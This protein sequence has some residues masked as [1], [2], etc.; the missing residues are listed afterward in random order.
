MKEVI[1]AWNESDL[2]C[3]VCSDDVP[4]GGRGT[5]LILVA[6]DR[7]QRSRT[8]VEELIGIV[9][10][11]GAYRQTQRDAADDASVRA[12]GAKADIRPER[13][14]GKQKRQMEGAIKPVESRSHVIL[15]AVSVIEVAHTQADAAE[16]EA[17]NGNAQT[18]ENLGRVIDD[19][20]V[21]GSARRRIGMADDGAKR[22]V[23]GS[24]VEQSF[25]TTS[26]AGEVFYLPD[27]RRDGVL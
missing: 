25:E 23:G 18:G 6:T 10:A 4:E 14:T 2:S 26:R 1:G 8:S 7:E 16:V 15:L 12:A 13:E 3:G 17:Q 20:G 27:M 9:A 22:R 11:G 21:H 19:F 5:E 24:S